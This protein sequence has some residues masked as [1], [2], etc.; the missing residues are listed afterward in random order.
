MVVVL[1]VEYLNE[2]LDD[3]YIEV[4]DAVLEY[5]DALVLDDRVVGEGLVNAPV[6]RDIISRPGTS[7]R[8]LF[9]E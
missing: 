5:I 9:S 3:E 2:L 1:L 6:G 8:H 4:V 7:I